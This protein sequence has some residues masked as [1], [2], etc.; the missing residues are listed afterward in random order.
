MILEFSA[1][2]EVDQFFRLSRGAGERL[3]DKHVLAVFEAQL[4]PVRNAS[5]RESRL[6]SHQYP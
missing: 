3:F 5:T 6:R 2:R 4:W 1:I